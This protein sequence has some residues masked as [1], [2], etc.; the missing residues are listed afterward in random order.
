M[1]S[2]VDSVL[3]SS[4]ALVSSSSG[5]FGGGGGGGEPSSTSITHL[6]RSTGEVRS[7]IEVSSSTL[8]CPSTPRR[9]DVG[10]RDAAEL[11]AEDVRDAVV[12]GEPLVD[13]RVIGGQQIRDRPILAN[14]AVD[15]ELGL[16]HHRLRQRRVP[17]RIEMMIGANLLDVLQAQPLR[18]KSRR[19]RF[20]S[21][22]GRAAASA[23]SR[24]PP[25]CAACPADAVFSNSASGIDPQMKNDSR[26]ARS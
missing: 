26:D 1:R 5:T 25:A 8:P 2:R 10:D 6:P 20:R 3:P 9:F 13:E 17:V 16:A 24:R 23:A 4:T 12:L 19:Q 7:A 14:Q 22:I 15:E 18:R 21:R 11:V